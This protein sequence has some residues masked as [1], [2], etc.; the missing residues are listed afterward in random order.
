[1]VATVDRWLSNASEED[2]KIFT[3][4][5]K[6]DLIVYHHGLG[7]QIRNEF[8]LWEREWEPKLINNVDHSEDHPDA[9]SMRIIEE[10][11]Q[12]RQ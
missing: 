10:V 6:D 2:Q 8:K 9:V 4:K 11:W 7:R 3:E 5:S 12:K 1:M